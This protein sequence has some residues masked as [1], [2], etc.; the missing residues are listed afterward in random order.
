MDG[1]A[2]ESYF[3][4]LGFEWAHI[5]DEETLCYSFDD[6]G[7]YATV[8]DDMGRIPESLDTPIIFTVYD[9]NDSF[10]WSVTLDKADDLGDV[11]ARSENTDELLATLQD[12]RQEH[13][14][15]FNS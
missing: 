5:D 4:P 6:Q 3:E 14:E 8:T 10:R 7:L 12:I 1:D 9:D 2:V 11:F 15:H 13:I